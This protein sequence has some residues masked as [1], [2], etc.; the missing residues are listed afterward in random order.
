MGVCEPDV[1]AINT[2]ML[3]V[4]VSITSSEKSELINDFEFKIPKQPI[5]NNMIAG[6]SIIVSNRFYTYFLH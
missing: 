6:R 4:A 5:I 1:A 2:N 3:I